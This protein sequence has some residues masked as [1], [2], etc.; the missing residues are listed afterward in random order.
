MRA[1]VV[2][3]NCADSATTKAMKQ[4]KTVVAGLSAAWP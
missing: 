2:S 1:T 3:Q 4:H